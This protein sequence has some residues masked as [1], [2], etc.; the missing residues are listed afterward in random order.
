MSASLFAQSLAIAR[1]DL[2]R[3]LRAGE[4][5]W[6]T[7]PFGAI[8]LLLVPM[9]VGTDVP[10][11]RQIGPGMYW[12]VVLLF[13]ILVA[14]RRTATDN[15]AQRDFLALAG[16]DPAA[17]FAGQAMASGLLLFGFQVI[18]GIVALA[19]YDPALGGWPWLLAIVPL[20]AI[21]LALLGT[22]AAHVAE[23]LGAG[24]ALVPLLVAP[25]AVPLL[26]AATEALESLQS[27]RSIVGWLM[28][29]LT[30]PLV[31]AVA[32]VM[33]ARPLQEAQ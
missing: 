21:G 7:V 29:M 11:L 12:V 3:E 16:L 22:L 14:V 28:L 15:P 26:L 4:V 30:V 25:L 31:L 9:A 19:L 17:R 27:G 18:V 5:L 8:A 23:N 1:R 2:V 20:T 6:I 13:G 24:S 32:G 33:T 10:L